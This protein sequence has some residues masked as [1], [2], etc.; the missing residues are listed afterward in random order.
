MICAGYK[1]QQDKTCIGD[2]GSPLMFSVASRGQHP[3]K[4]VLGGVMS[5]AW[6]NFCMAAI[7]TTVI[8]HTPVWGETWSGSS[9][10]ARATRGVPNRDSAAK[11]FQIL[12]K[13]QS[14]ANISANHSM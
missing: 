3:T 11:D 7:A 9:S 1:E 8:L 13:E 14:F 12:T 6:K 2:S 5:G 4:W 10:K